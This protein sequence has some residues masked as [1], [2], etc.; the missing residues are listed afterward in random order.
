MFDY[1]IDK[2][3]IGDDPALEKI[4]GEIK[5]IAVTDVHVER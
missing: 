2:H 3:L 5:D 1:D 4:K